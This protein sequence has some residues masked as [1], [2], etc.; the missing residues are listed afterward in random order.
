MTLL[1]DKFHIYRHFQ[2]F[3][4]GEH[5]GIFLTRGR[6]ADLRIPGMYLSHIFLVVEFFYSA[7]VEKIFRPTVWASKTFSAAKVFGYGL[8]S[9]DVD[10]LGMKRRHRAVDSED[11]VFL[12]QFLV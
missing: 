6:L 12:E 11:D 3:S 10:Q 8:V 2:K 4:V 5:L 7:W 9:I 1:T